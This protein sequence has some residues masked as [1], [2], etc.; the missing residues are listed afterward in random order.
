VLAAPDLEELVREELRG[1]VAELVARLVPELVA[2][3]LNGHAASTA[4]SLAGASQSAQDATEGSTEGKSSRSTSTAPRARRTC[5]RCGE[6]KDLIAFGR[7][8]RVCRRC[9]GRAERERAAQRR[10]RIREAPA[11]TNGVDTVGPLDP[12]STV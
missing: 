9:R 12:S 7:G 1:P 2:E 11:S 10:A 6:T 5:T 3:A 8:R 4:P